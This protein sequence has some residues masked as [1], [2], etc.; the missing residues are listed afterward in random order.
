MFRVYVHTGPPLFAQAK[1]CFFLWGYVCPCV[2]IR[3]TLPPNSYA[4][5]NCPS[6]FCVHPFFEHL[7]CSC[8]VKEQER[9]LSCFLSLSPLSY[10]HHIISSRERETDYPRDVS[11]KGLGN[12]VSENPGTSHYQKLQSTTTTHTHASHSCLRKKRAVF[13]DYLATNRLEKEESNIS[14]RRWPITRGRGIKRHDFSFLS[15]SLS[16]SPA[17]SERIMLFKFYG[18]FFVESLSLPILSALVSSSQGKEE[19]TN[20]GDLWHEERGEKP[21][22]SLFLLS[23]DR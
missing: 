4:G 12:S 3:P 1:Q 11:Q 6:T 23:P 19:G 21:Q 10:S 18:L 15:A 13:P 8:P 20:Q 17:G 5:T 2:L 14:V 9:A 7:F 22:T 16:L